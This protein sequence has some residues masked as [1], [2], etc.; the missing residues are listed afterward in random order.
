MSISSIGASPAASR[1]W[2]GVAP[3][4]APVAS[5]KVDAKPAPTATLRTTPT[6]SELTSVDVQIEAR[7]TGGQQL[8]IVDETTG[9]IY[10]QLP[11]EQVVKVLEDVLRQMQDRGNL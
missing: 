11:P 10:C 2:T 7:S 6:Q 3:T 8:T 9:Q 5:P 4:R 1:A